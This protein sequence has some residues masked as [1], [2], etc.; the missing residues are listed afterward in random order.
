MFYNEGWVKDTAG[1][2]DSWN[3]PLG[4]NERKSKVLQQNW[5]QLLLIMIMMK[6]SFYTIRDLVKKKVQ[7]CRKLHCDIFNTN[8]YMFNNVNIQIVLLKANAPFYLLAA[9][10]E[11]TAPLLTCTIDEIFLKI[12]RCTISPSKMPAHAMALVKKTA[13]Y[14]IERVL[15]K[16]I[17][18]TYSA[19]LCYK[20]YIQ[21]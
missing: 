15:M 7:L 4:D 9:K 2:F 16:D 5:W 12:R 20:K 13:K 10:N 3:F 14:P 8:R 6:D 21:G 1:K 11:T 19:S 17:F 18:I